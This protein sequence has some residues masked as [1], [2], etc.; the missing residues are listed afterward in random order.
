[1][2]PEEFRAQLNDRKAG[3]ERRAQYLV[4][5]NKYE[6]LWDGTDG[7]FRDPDGL[8]ELP[9]FLVHEAEEDI[10]KRRSLGIFWKEYLLKKHDVE[11]EKDDLVDEPGEGLGLFRDDRHGRPIGSIDYS[12]GRIERVKR[13]NTLASIETGADRQDIDENHKAALQST[14][15]ASAHIADVVNKTGEVVGQRPMCA[16][17]AS[18]TA[19]G[20]DDEWGSCVCPRALAN[21]DSPSEPDPPSKKDSR[22]TKRSKGGRGAGT[23]GKTLKETARVLGKTASFPSL[24]YLLLCGLAGE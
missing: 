13:V 17:P 10:Q 18:S 19:D 8:V 20:S 23:T 14:G 15:I 6:Q 24:Y 2:Q 1:M 12:A 22:S 3:P 7:Q 4:K 9:E 11:Y 21:A 16:V 5:L